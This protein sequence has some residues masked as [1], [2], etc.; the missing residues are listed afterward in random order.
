MIVDNFSHELANLSR[1]H[2][3]ANF[4]PGKIC[5]CELGV[6]KKLSIFFAIACRNFYMIVDNFSH[7]LVHLSRLYSIAKFMPGKNL[8]V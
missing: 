6:C 5:M 7:E 1:L 4:M 2:S 3:I 8:H